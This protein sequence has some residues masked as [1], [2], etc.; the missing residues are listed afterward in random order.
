MSKVT[1]LPLLFAAVAMAGSS[2]ALAA[3][4][5]ITSKPF[6]TVKGKQVQ[7]FT[8]RNA[9]GMEAH[10]TNYGGIIQA[11]LV[12]DRGGQLGD[13]SLG[14]DNVSSYVKAT[15]YFGALIGRYGNRIAKGRFKVDGKTYKL[16]TNDGPNHLHGGKVGFDKVI[17]APKASMTAAGPTL[18]LTYTSKDGE[19]GYPGNLKVKAV[20][21]LTNRNELK[22]DFTA[23]TDKAT[24]INLT[25]HCY[26]N[27]AGAGAGDVLNHYVRIN[28]RKMVPVDNTLIPTGKLRNIAGT[29]FDFSKAMAIGERINDDDPQ[30]KLGKTGYDHCWVVNKP[31]GQYG[32]LARVYEP[33]SGRILEV[34]SNEPGVQFYTGNFLDGTNIGKGGITYEFRNA[35]CLEP[36]HYPDTPNQPNFPS[37]ILRPGQTYHHSMAFRFSIMK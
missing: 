35:F 7:L 17:W 32:L 27:L 20:Y 4:P 36:E 37:C 10:I 15:P 5:S 18:T 11:L 13:V 29:A 33:T 16:A 25:N 6:G 26:F 28:S 24:P 14:Y 30:L 22:L 23:T 34:F 21:T 31:L 2:M 3:K 12:P 19:E 9:R 8:L 1:K